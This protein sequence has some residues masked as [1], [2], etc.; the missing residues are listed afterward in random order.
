MALRSVLPLRSPKRFWSEVRLSPPTNTPYCRTMRRKVWSTKKTVK[1]SNTVWLVC[2]IFALRVGKVCG[3]QTKWVYSIGDPPSH[4]TPPPS[5]RRGVAS[6][7]PRRAER[8][9]VLNAATQ[10]PRAAGPIGFGQGFK[11][12]A[13]EPTGG[14]HK[15]AGRQVIARGAR[16]GQLGSTKAPGLGP[17]EHGHVRGSVGSDV[18]NAG[19]FSNG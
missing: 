4:K 11:D 15:A 18:R 7:H 17:P 14:R 8:Q 6:D 16:Q 19:R 3:V 5:P 10:N 9:A 12:E 2:A 1:N 13:A